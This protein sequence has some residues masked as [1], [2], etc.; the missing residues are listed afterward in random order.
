M[1]SSTRE[2]AT[3]EQDAPLQRGWWRTLWAR[4]RRRKATLAAAGVLAAVVLMALLAPWISPVDPNLQRLDQRLLPPVWAP[5]GVWPHVLGTDHLG[6]DVLSRIVWGSRVSLSVGVSAVAVSGAIGVLL[7][8]IS[9]FYPGTFVETLIMRVADVQL[10]IPSI[11]LAIAV[12][13]VLGPNLRNLII[14]LAITGWVTYARVV[15]AHALSLR[16]QEFVQAARAIGVPAWRILWRHVLPNLLSSVIV[17]ATMQV[18]TFIISEAS[19]SFL[20]LGV[21]LSTPTWGGMLSEAQLYMFDAK[22]LATFP[23]LAIMVT[24]LSINLVGDLLRD[25]FDPRLS[26][27]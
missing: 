27:D 5:G 7:G 25:T 4:G 26:V 13:S 2:S 9:G 3:I 24:V 23:G 6:R 11:L 22:W 10:A 18:A 1:V 20:G 21:P 14:V 12:I 15:R 8:L 19:L 17:I 16:Q